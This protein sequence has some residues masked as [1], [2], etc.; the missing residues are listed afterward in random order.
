VIGV[1]GG[2]VLLAAVPDARYLY[3]VFPF[4]TLGSTVAL[5]GLRTSQKPIF[6][7]GILA[8]VAAGLWN[9]YYFPSGDWI[10]REFYSSPFFGRGP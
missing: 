10:H 7:A 3:P 9:T 6:Q 4:M 2:T 5:A 1:G 8:A